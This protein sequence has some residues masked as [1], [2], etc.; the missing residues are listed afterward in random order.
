M[1]LFLLLF[2][3]FFPQNKQEAI[4]FASTKGDKLNRKM[5]RN[6][7]VSKTKGKQKTY[8][9]R[10]ILVFNKAFQLRSE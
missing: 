3:I 5:T 1:D 6:V 9:L 7:V 8:V 10:S 2:F 4:S